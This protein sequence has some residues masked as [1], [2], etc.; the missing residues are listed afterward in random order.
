MD[1]GSL[2]NPKNYRMTKQVLQRLKNVKKEHCKR[3]NIL[4]KVGDMVSSKVG[5]SCGNLN[6]YHTDCFEGLRF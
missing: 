6:M 3:C 1:A 4:F 2:S 5:F